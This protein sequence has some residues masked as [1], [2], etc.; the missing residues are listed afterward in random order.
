[1]PSR[2]R[3]VR[4]Q[5]MLDPDVSQRLDRKAGAMGKTRS[6]FTR[7]A[8]EVIDDPS[9]ANGQ[10]GLYTEEE[11]C[12]WTVAF[13]DNLAARWGVTRKQ[14]MARLFKTIPPA[15]LAVI[16]LAAWATVAFVACDV[17]TWGCVWDMA[18]LQIDEL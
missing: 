13:V 2:Q 7:D 4:W 11:V 8:L 15:V 1:M 10:A 6:G 17:L 9:K 18:D 5:A 16:Y 12:G 3:K 14:A